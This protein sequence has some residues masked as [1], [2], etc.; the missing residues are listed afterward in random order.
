MISFDTSRFGRI[1]VGKDK[2]IEFPNGLIGFPDVKRFILM[3]YK[4]TT[5][6]WLQAVDNPEIAFIVTHPFELFPDF[7]VKVENSAK[8]ALGIENEDDMVTLAI[9]RVEEDSVT[10]NLQ[11]PLVINSMNKTGMQIVNEDPRF[12]CKTPLHS[13]PSAAVK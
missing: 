5:L 6:K 2:V 12:T 10:A 3:D 13:P 11:G 1:E 8:K 7:S 4:D 9:L